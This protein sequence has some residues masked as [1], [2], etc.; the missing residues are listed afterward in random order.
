MEIDDN[1]FGCY[2]KSVFCLMS[3]QD[4]FEN[5][6]GF[7]IL[8]LLPTPYSLLPTPYSLL[9]TPYYLLPTPY[10]LLPKIYN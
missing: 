9:P 3:Y 5:A 10:Y 7:L 2:T 6:I 8:S 1:S 4:I